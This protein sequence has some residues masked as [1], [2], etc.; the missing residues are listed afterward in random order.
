M[1]GAWPLTALCSGRLALVPFW[2]MMQLAMLA[3]FPPSWPI[4]A[5]LLN[6][7]WKE[8]M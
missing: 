4:D 1:D 6:K 5:L 3:R 8:R 7:G 2:F